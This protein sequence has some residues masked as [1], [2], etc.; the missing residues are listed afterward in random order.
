MT[1]STSMGQAVVDFLYSDKH[2]TMRPGLTN[3]CDLVCSQ[4][5]ET[6][7]RRLDGEAKVDAR[8]RADWAVRGAAKQHRPPTG[9]PDPLVLRY[10]RCIPYEGGRKGR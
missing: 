10:P 5:W 9:P 3:R 6:P 7:S 2:T 1:N 4:R 8:F